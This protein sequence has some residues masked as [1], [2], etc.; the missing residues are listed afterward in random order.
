MKTK[1][2]GIDAVPPGPGPT[3]RWMSQVKESIELLTGNRGARPHSLTNYS[4][5]TLPPAFPGGLAYATDGRKNGEAAAKGT[6]VMV[7]SDVTHWCAC[8][9]GAAVTK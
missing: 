9:T 3:M 1:Y 8:D 6:G 2:P 7:F 4:V 5:S